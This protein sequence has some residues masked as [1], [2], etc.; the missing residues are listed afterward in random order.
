MCFYTFEQIAKYLEDNLTASVVS[1]RTKKK[2]HLL[3]KKILKMSGEGSIFITELIII[4]R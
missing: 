3:V 4:K 1:S 2:S